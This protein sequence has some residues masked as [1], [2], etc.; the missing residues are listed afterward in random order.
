MSFSYSL[1]TLEM[2]RLMLRRL[3]IPSIA[4]LLAACSSAPPPERFPDIHFLNEPPL[5]LD[6]ASVEVVSTF[7]PGFR[8]PNVEHEF[9]IPPQRALENL[10]HDRYRATMSRPDHIAR[11]TI[12]DASVREV[13]LPLS[14]GIQ[15]ALTRE[16]SERYDAHAAVKLE[17]MDATGFVERT[18]TAQATVSRT[19]PEGI[20][21][22]D[23]DQV[24]YEM[25]QSLARDIDRELDRQVHAIFPP[26]VH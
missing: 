1:S 20:T 25:S 9:A 10:G 12:D 8:A 3:A 24:W 15:G 26:Y 16:Q 11:F 22:N 6:V 18:A 5:A 17:I 14:D 13:K 2:P 21:L 23:R 4:L 19:V 7:Q